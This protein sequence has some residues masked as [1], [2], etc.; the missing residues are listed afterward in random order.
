MK[1]RQSGFTLIE[2][3][4]VVAIAAI[5]ASMAVPSFRTMLVKRSVQS[6]AETLVS[7]MRFARTEALT[8][9]ARVV[10]CSLAANSTSACA[11]SSGSWQNGW[12]VF[13]DMNSS[14]SLDAGD[15]VVRVQQE[16]PNIASIQSSTP[17]GD[18]TKFTFEPAG[19]A[20]AATQSFVFTPTGTVPAG[21]TRLVCISIQGRPSL[22]SEGVSACL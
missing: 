5:L 17:G 10:I 12:I 16:L 13:V 20:K 14:G 19:W 7:D 1:I 18:L 4:V 11:G 6:A 8:R 22:R 3:L 21:T 15:D 9:S 2:V